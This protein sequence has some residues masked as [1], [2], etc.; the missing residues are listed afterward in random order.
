MSRSFLVPLNLNQNEVQ[1]ARIQNLSSA[2]SSPVVG[3]IYYSTASSQ[4]WVWN[5]TAW[6]GLDA[7]RLVGLIPTAAVANF[8][9]TVQGYS[10]DKF[11]TPVANVDMGGHNLTGLGTPVNGN[12]AAP[13]SWVTSQVQMSSAGIA[14]KAPVKFVTTG[15][16]SLSGLAAIDG[17]SVAGG[18]RVLVA[19]QTVA[20][21][22]GVYIASS[23]SWARATPAE[24]AE[25]SLWL[26]TEGLTQASTQWTCANTAAITY[27]STAIVIHQFNLAQV[28]DAGVGLQLL[29]NTFS[30]NPKAG[31]GI[32]ADGTGAYLDP[33]F[34]T[35]KFATTIGDTV[36][37]Q[38]SISHNLN[39]QD[40]TVQVHQNANP[41]GVVE[42]DM[43][44]TSLNV[45]T[46]AFAAPPAT[47]AYRVVCIG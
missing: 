32:I 14:S 10:L 29:S 47:S 28:Y 37:T 16:V 18:D 24:E 38:F 8:A 9:T 34:I 27:G 33:S 5:G 4:I 41:Y 30:I 44:L 1:N 13:M 43:S 11:A 19:A 40:I 25:G 21:G 35:R 36:A 31:G 22:N 42:C 20:T 15:N 3:Q 12:D 45:A 7:T 2:P 39:S 17:V 26:V 23:G 46:L 6:V